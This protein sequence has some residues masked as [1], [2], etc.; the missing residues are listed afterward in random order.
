MSAGQLVSQRRSTRPRAHEYLSLHFL[1]QTLRLPQIEQMGNLLHEPIR[2]NV[3]RR[4]PLP[5]S[6]PSDFGNP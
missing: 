6:R 3:P 1:E 5:R 2:I 4:D